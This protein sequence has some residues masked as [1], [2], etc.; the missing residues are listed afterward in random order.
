MAE[1]PSPRHMAINFFSVCKATSNGGPALHHNG[2][3]IP[4]V[5]AGYHLFQEAYHRDARTRSHFAF[6]KADESGYPT[7][8]IPGPSPTKEEVLGSDCD[9]CSHEEIKGGKV[10]TGSQADTVNSMLWDATDCL[11]HQ[12]DRNHQ[13]YVEHH[14]CREDWCHGRGPLG[15]NTSAY[16][17]QRTI[18]PYLSCLERR[19]GPSRNAGSRLTSPDVSI[20]DIDHPS[21]ELPKQPIAGPSHVATD[22]APSNDIAALNEL[23][24]DAYKEYYEEVAADESMNMET[25]V[26]DAVTD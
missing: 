23:P 6:C 11:R 1:Q 3:D 21:T 15:T 7:I 17:R 4:E 12:K 25:S 16:I 9:L 19:S 2:R 8:R 14:E 5:P 22:P 20:I 13:G 18:D 26:A 24:G 10:L